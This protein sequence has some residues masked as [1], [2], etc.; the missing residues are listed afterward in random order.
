M[1]KACP[2]AR[3]RKLTWKGDARDE[4]DCVVDVSTC[5]YVRAYRYGR[6]GR[7][8]GSFSALKRRRVQDARFAR[9]SRFS[10]DGDRA[11]SG[12]YALRDSARAVRDTKPPVCVFA[13]NVCFRL[14]G[15]NNNPR[16]FFPLSQNIKI[17]FIFE[18]KEISYCFF[19]LLF[20]LSA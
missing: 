18:C 8:S 10:L 4:R 14:R 9:A 17:I 19:F 16:N 1:E 3:R 2:L 20:D 15:D 6:M 5:E 11:K 13:K 7:A 12:R